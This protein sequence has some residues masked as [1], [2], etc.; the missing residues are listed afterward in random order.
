MTSPGS[1]KK[2]LSDFISREAVNPLDH[3][4]AKGTKFNKQLMKEVVW[5]E[6]WADRQRIVD[7][8]VASDAFDHKKSI[9]ASNLQRYTDQLHNLDA[10]KE[11]IAYTRK[12]DDTKCKLHGAIG[13]A[14]LGYDLAFGTL[15]GVHSTLYHDTVM[16][17]GSEKHAHLCDKAMTLEHFGCFGM[18]EIGHGSNVSSV[19]TT[20]TYDQAINSPAPTAA[21]FWIGALGRT[22]NICAVFAQL[23]VN[24]ENH[25]VH[26]FAVDIRDY[27]T[28]L[29]K[30]NVI[31]G[32]TGEKIGNNGIDN[33]FMHFDHYRV[34]YDTLLD[35]F[36]QITEDGKFKSSIRDKE[37]RFG[38]MMSGLHRGRMGV[39]F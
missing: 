17:L 1:R 11:A 27:D 23:I 14:V 5:G 4:R 21:K 29:P 19:E 26:A 24:D 3:Y 16:V 25:G 37:K 30:E 32:N 6:Y 9:G 2:K 22:A 34:P 28:H 15:L 13:A 20:A 39:L 36:S 33:G 31:I 12:L 10:V 7:A 8:M 38:T 35:R 18:T